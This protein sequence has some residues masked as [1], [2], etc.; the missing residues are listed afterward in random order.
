MY[1]ASSVTRFGENE[2]FLQN[3]KSLE[4]FE[5]YLEFGNILNVLWQIFYA[6][7]QLLFVCGQR[8]KYLVIT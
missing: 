2:S 5:V 8:P 6:I 4:L 3:L 1:I 7:R